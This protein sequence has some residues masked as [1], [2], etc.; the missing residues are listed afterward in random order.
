MDRS[1]RYYC[2]VAAVVFAIFTAYPITNKI[3]EERLANDWAHS[4]LHLL[5]MLFAGWAGWAAKGVRPARLFVWAIGG[6]YGFLGVLGWFVPGLIL[7]TSLAIPLGPVD[8][9][10]HLMVGIPAAI[11]A[12]LDAVR[13]RT[14]PSRRP[15]QPAQPKRG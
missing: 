7:A 12:G 3:I 10:F 5:S 15:S 1:Y 2:R 13:S 14:V 4:A 9:V 8:N 11:I 6:G